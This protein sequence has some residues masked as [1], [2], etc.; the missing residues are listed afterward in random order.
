[1]PFVYNHPAKCL[2]GHDLLF[3]HAFAGQSLR[4]PTSLVDSSPARSQLQAGSPPPR[5]WSLVGVLLA[6]LPLALPRIWGLLSGCLTPGVHPYPMQLSVHLS[7]PSETYSLTVQPSTVPPMA[8][9]MRKEALHVSLYDSALIHPCEH[10]VT[11][12]IDMIGGCLMQG[13]S[14]RA[15]QESGS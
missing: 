6:C 10:S 5:C 2:A 3:R 13:G 9:P 12:F 4:Q 14:G 8:R 1:M 15:S 11:G 7:Q